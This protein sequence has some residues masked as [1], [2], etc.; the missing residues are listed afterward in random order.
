MKVRYYEEVREFVCVF[1]CGER[2]KEIEIDR[3]TGEQC[4]ALFVGAADMRQRK[5]PSKDN[6]KQG[7]GGDERDCDNNK[8][9]FQKTRGEKKTSS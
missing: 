7:S 5:N 9:L 3:A 8:K 2:E 1:V 6:N 4:Q